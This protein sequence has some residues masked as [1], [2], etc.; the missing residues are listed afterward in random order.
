MPRRARTPRA[1]Q[2][3]IDIW[4]W[5]AAENPTAAD[6]FL[7]SIDEKLQLLAASPR[8]G[9]LRPDFA[10]GVRIFPVRRYLVLY[11]ENREGI[12]VVCIVHA[13]RQIKQA[14]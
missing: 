5:I 9:P 10:K 12:E 2:D 6:R 14:L 11:R 4:L 1:R 7:D 3:L 13:M 8:L